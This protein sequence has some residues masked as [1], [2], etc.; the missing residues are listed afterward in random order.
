VCV[1]IDKELAANN[2]VRITQNEFTD[3]YEHDCQLNQQLCCHD[4][5]SFD[6]DL[7]NRMTS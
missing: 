6:M 7:E 4:Y 3:D 1:C 5:K 2:R